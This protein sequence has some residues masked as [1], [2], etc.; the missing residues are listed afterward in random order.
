MRSALFASFLLLPLL[1]CETTPERN[2]LDLTA[3]VTSDGPQNK[4]AKGTELNTKP[5]AMAAQELF[6]WQRLYREAP[7]AKDRGLV[8]EKLESKDKGKGTSEDD[9]SFEQRLQTARNLLAIGRRDESKDL[10]LD[11][12]KEDPKQIDVQLELA[13]IYLAESNTERAFDYLAS[14]RKQ[15][16]A[17]EK[18]ST[19]LSFRYRYALASAY[20]QSQNKKKGHQILSDLISKAPDFLP[21]YAALSQ[22]YLQGRHPEIAE[23]IAKRGLDRGPDDPRLLNLVAVSYLQRNR[24]EEARIWLEKT[25]TVNP[26]FVPALVNRAHLAILRREYARAENDLQKAVNLDPLSI[27]GQ[28]ALGL[29]HKKTGRLTSA[30]VCLEKAVQIDPQNPFARYHLGLLLAQD[31]KDE[32]AALQLFYDVLQARDDDG[33]IK[34][35]AKVQ[36]Q[37]IRDSRL[38]SK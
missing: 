11:L 2:D 18:P 19:E 24:S 4:N 16:E 37:S 30:R 28:M 3:D 20:I 35:L 22:S 38:F 13:H 10:Y 17:M 34:N 31:F 8:R 25:L 12:L 1:A 5:E 23:F 32:P 36:I 21:A 26:D 27:D 6:N 29:L 33:E 7:S 14:I 9:R 15:L